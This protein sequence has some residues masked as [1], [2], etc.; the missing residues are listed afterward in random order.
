MPV[1][2]YFKSYFRVLLYKKNSYPLP[3]QF[4]MDF[5]N[6]ADTIIFSH[7]YIYA[8]QCTNMAVIHIQISYTK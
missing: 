3:A 5:K 1:M 6:L 7:F 8:L 2:R 4:T